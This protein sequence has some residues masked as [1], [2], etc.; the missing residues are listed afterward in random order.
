ML[1]CYEKS[2]LSKNLSLI[3]ANVISN[4]HSISLMA[5]NDIVINRG[6]LLRLIKMR[7]NLEETR[8]K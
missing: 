6:N 4:T 2:I 3:E 5:L 8:F 1:F 7:V